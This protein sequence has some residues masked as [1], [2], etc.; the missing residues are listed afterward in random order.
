MFVAI[1]TIIGGISMTTTVNWE[2]KL[3]CCTTN[4]GLSNYSGYCSTI[5][6][7]G[8]LIVLILSYV[9]LLSLCGIDSFFTLVLNKFVRRYLARVRNPCI[10]CKDYIPILVGFCSSM[11]VFNQD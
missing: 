10:D 11:R 2:N 7:N 9:A 5:S 4:V 3:V 1:T 8:F 6:N